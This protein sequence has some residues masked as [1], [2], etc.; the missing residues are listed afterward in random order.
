MLTMTDIRS[1]LYSQAKY[2]IMHITS[3]HGA[4]INGKKVGREEF[5]QT[6]TDWGKDDNKKV[7]NLPLF[8]TF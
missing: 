5:F 1:W 6:L 2:N 4:V 3:K 8:D 7:C